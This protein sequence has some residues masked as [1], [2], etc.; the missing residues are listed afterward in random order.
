MLQ[1]GFANMLELS[2]PLTDKLLK[3]GFSPAEI[4]ELLND[5]NYLIKESKD[6]TTIYI[7]Q[8]LENLGWGIQIIDESLF[9]EILKHLFSN[10]DT[11]KQ[12]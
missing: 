1:Q 6:Y 12:N 2:K 7:N 5:L 3:K 8:E 11:F 9:K 10:E 4:S